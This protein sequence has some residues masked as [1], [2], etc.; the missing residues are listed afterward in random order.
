MDFDEMLQAWKAQDERPLYGINAD[1]LRLVLRGEQAT[2]RRMERRD[3]WMVYLC[4]GGMALFAAFWLWV[5]IVVRGPALQMV[6][7]AGGA[8]LFVAWVIAFWI[9]RR[10][11]SRRERG[12]GNSLKDE[13]GRSLSMVEFQIANGSFAKG[14]MWTAPV[15]VGATL[16]YWLSFQINTDTGFTPMT[17]FWMVGVLV[18]SAVFVPYAASIK[19]KKRL[20]PRRERLSE[21]LEALEAGE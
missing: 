18:W 3:K 6:A 21:L 5:L 8:I 14:V 19:V 10:R 4:G 9:S 12:F 20:E 15:L 13:I 2:I 16:I 1:L 7:A 11:Q 17:H